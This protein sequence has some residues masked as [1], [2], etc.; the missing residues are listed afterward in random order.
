[1]IKQWIDEG[2]MWGKH[3]AFAEINAPEIPNINDRPFRNPI[4]A[5][6]V[7]NLKREKLAPSPRA[8]KTTLI[9]CVTLDLT[10]LPPTIEEV[11]AFLEDNL[12]DAYERVVDRLLNSPAYGERMAWDWMEVARYADSNGYQSD[13]ERTMWP[14]RD[15]VVKALNANMPYDQFTIWQLAGDLLPN[16]TDDQ[17]LATGFCRNH[18]PRKKMRRRMQKRS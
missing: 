8:D 5:F 10:G 12:P 9:R 17:K 4:D 16:A 2:A 11:T 15:W 18:H 3:W 1:V 13:A 6:V 7:A 14:W